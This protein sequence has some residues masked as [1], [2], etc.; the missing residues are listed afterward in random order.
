MGEKDKVLEIGVEGGGATIY[1]TPLDTGGW[2]FHVEGTSMDLNKNDDEDWRS[3]TSEPVQTIAEALRSIAEDGS[4]VFF[5]P[6]SVHPEYRT[7]VWELVQE[8]ASK[9]TQERPRMW[10]E[11][12]RDWQRLCLEKARS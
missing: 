1:R 12:N 9:L 10:Q 11:R 3:W 5:H 6:I 2:R 7:I 4:W 8:T